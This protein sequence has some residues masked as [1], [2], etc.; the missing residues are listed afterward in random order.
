[1]YNHVQNV[2]LNDPNRL[3]QWLE[4]S[5][6]GNGIVPYLYEGLAGR[7]V[8]V[9]SPGG[10]L[11][12]LAYPASNAWNPSLITDLSMEERAELMNQFD[13]TQVSIKL[14]VFNAIWDQVLFHPT[15]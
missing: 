15:C 9:A 1:M 12:V 6:Q 2:N 8:Y 14:E 13:L 11:Q 3:L 4:D 10:S 7:T 5:S